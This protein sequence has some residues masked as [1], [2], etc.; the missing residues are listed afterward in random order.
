MEEKVLNRQTRFEGKLLKLEVV[1]VEL[2]DGK[3]AIREVVTH[4]NA[5]CAAVLTRE[6]KWVFVRQ[7]RVPA[8]SL[9]VEVPAGK[10]DPG[11]NPD[12]AI[13]RELQE[14]VGYQRGR[15]E[16]LMEFWSTPGFCNERM[17]AYLVSEAELDERVIVEDEFLELVEVSYEE[18]ITMALDGR[19]ADSKSIAAVLA[20]ARLLESR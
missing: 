8:E 17:T 15:L 14:E 7:Y 4:P 2:A 13:V 19:L 5:V 9:L 11:E 6:R 16:K 1:D 10:I 12:D 18:G 3:P 20:G